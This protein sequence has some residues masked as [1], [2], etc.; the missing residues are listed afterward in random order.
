[1]AQRKA[2]ILDV[3]CNEALQRGAADAVVISPSKVFTAAW[4]RLRCQYGCSEYGQCLTCP[5]NSPTPE[6]TR[7]VLDEYRSAILLHGADWASLRDIARELERKIFLDGYYKAFSFVCGPCWMCKNCVLRHLKQGKP[8]AC[9]HP[10]L[11][12]PSMEAAGIDVYATAH[13]AGL[14]IEVVRAEGCPTNYYAL[15]LVE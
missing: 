13:A 15:L 6:T 3:Y 9:R 14:P 4:V 11:A 10:D 12:R 2:K 1:M 8:A 5:P 7:R